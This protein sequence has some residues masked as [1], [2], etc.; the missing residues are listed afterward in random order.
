M[1]PAQVIDLTGSSDTEDCVTMKHTKIKAIGD[2]IRHRVAGPHHTETICVEDLALSE[3]STVL[4]TKQTQLYLTARD[5]GWACGYRNCQ[6]LISSLI[7]LP[8]LNTVP[9]VNEL[10]QML[11]Q[12]WHAGFDRDGCTQLG[13]V[14]NTRKWIGATEVY[15]ILAHLGVR[16]RIVDFHR[17]TGANGTH[18]ALF[19]WIVE[20][21]T[22][23]ASKDS[24]TRFTDKHPLYLQHQGHSRTVV[25]VEMAD[26][27]V[28]VLV[29]D[30]DVPVAQTPSRFLLS[31]TKHARQYQIVYVDSE[32]NS[33]AQIPKVISSTRIP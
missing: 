15:C 33:Q 10:Q 22:C 12:A 4:C 7:P 19:A 17:A 9:Q 26:E 24:S 32:P 2:Y 14:V 25:G 23:G 21:F 6:M 27:G 29:F 8:I 13:R 20:Y 3:S 31:H 18:P 11:E 30:P 1:D 28:C 16:A 5:R